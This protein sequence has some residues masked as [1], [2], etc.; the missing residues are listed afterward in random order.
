MANSARR[1]RIAA[2]W[3]ALREACNAQ[4]RAEMKGRAGGAVVCL[5]GHGCGGSAACSMVGRLQNLVRYLPTGS[6]PD[7]WRTIVEE[8][9]SVM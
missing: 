4:H 1:E 9:R 6:L 3:Q 7:E 5:C 8:L 2:D